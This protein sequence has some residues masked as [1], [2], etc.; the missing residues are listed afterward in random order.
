MITGIVNGWAFSRSLQYASLLGASATRMV[1]TTD[2]V[3]TESQA[4]Q[5]IAEHPVSVYREYPVH[6]IERP[7]G[8]GE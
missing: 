7:V 5:A 3:L 8:R 1:G 2:G 6:P 4:K